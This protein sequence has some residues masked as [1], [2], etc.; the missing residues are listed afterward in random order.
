[1]QNEK[2]FLNS[3]DRALALPYALGMLSLSFQPVEEISRE[4]ADA[5]GPSTT[6]LNLTECGFRNF[7]H[8]ESFTALTTLVLDKNELEDL[9]GCPPIETLKC[10]WFNNNKITDLPGFLDQ[11]LDLFPR[12][13]ELSMMRN[14]ACPGLMDIQQPDLAA[15]R[16]YR[17][18]VI[19][20]VPQLITVDGVDVEPYERK[21]A[22][23]R[24]EYA[25]KREPEA[26][27][28]PPIRKSSFYRTLSSMISS[29]LQ[30]VSFT[31]DDDSD[32]NTIYDAQGVVPLKHL[33]P[34]PAKSGD[35]AK[36]VVASK[37]YEGLHSEGNR[38]ITN[39][40]L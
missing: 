6:T 37:M 18:Y 19:Y 36:L 28:Q 14:P 21:E 32:M 40:H 25:I 17:M 20:R 9:T 23:L 5:K 26:R 27:F 31:G 12:I 11:V 4:L 24:G 13:E 2:Q 39:H 38:F 1:M 15:C 33:S 29:A 10:L 35:G 30:P 34:V 16:S 3:H 8:L 22:A 7:H